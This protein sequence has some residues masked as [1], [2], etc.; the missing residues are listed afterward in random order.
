MNIQV[1]GPFALDPNSQ[2]LMS[3]D[4]SDLVSHKDE[5]H[6]YEY[7]VAI[8]LEISEDGLPRGGSFETLVGNLDINVVCMGTHLHGWGTWWEETPGKKWACRI[9]RVSRHSEEGDMQSS[10]NGSGK[11]G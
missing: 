1:A 10:A 2:E 5:N 8:V 11:N 9:K 4:I 6:P 3:V 7:K